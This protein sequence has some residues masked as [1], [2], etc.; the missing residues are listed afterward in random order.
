MSEL[1]EQVDNELLK[2]ELNC[3]EH[4]KRKMSRNG[5]S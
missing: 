4:F 3:Q 1:D 2:K 5:T